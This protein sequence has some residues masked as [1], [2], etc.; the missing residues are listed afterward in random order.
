MAQLRQQGFGT[1]QNLAGQAFNQQQSLAAGQLGLAQQSPA[2][3]GQQIASLT[4]LGAQQAASSTRINSST[5]II[6]K[7]S[8]TTLRSSTTIW[9]WCYTI[10]CRISR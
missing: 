3:L 10:N 6:I 9:F 8:F 7:T 2:L 5:T 1:A 4:G